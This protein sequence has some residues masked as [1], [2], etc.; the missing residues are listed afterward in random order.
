MTWPKGAMGIQLQFTA[1]PLFSFR[2]SKWMGNN[3]LRLKHVLVPFHIPSSKVREKPHQNFKDLLHNKRWDQWMTLNPTATI[4]CHC[5]EYKD[6]LS[7]HCVLH[8]H[9]VAG[10]EDVSLIHPSCSF[11]GAG[12]AASTCFPSR[13]TFVKVNCKQFEA[14]RTKHGLP[15]ELTQAFE[16][17]MSTEWCHHILALKS[18]PRLT[19]GNIQAARVN[20]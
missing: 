3:V 10:F 13:Q 2:V 18:K 15:A 4:P 8:G 6:L 12:S 9:V 5:Q 14:W 19:W 11:L 16:D 20:L 17:L 7:D 1:D